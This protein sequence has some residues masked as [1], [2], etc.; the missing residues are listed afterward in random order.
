MAEVG[1]E[2]LVGVGFL[3]AE[4]VVDV[5]GGEADAEGV[6]R[7]GVGG[8]DEEEE[9]GGVGAAGDGDGDTVA[10]VDGGLG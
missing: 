4:G 2:G 10:G 6:A 7:E 9:R 3:G 8:V 1:D 5:Y